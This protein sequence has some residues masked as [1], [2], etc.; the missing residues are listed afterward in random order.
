MFTI[1]TKQKPEPLTLGNAPLQYVDE[2]TYL[3]VNFDKRQTWK[4]QIGIAESKARKKLCSM[5]KLA[6]TNC[7]ANE[8]ILKQVYHGNIRPSLE[9]GSGAFM[10][11]A[12]SH[13]DNLEKVQNQALRVITGAMRSTPIEKMQKITGIPP[14]KRRF[15]SKALTLYT[16]AEALKDHPL[17]DRTKQR[18]RG[19]LGRESFIGQAKALKEKFK[20]DL[21]IDIEAIQIAD[22]WKEAPVQYKIQTAVPHLGPKEVTSKEQ[23]RS[24]TLEMIEDRYPDEAWTHI[25]T[26]GSASDAVKNR[27]AGVYIQNPDGTTKVMSEPT[28]LHCTNYRAEVEALTI[29][30]ENID[31]DDLQESQIVFLTDALSV[32]QDLEKGNLPKLRTALRKLECTRVTL[33]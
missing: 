4:S 3:G 24:L 5:R 14:L 33:Q 28:G 20:E 26:D 2:Q 17:H 9:F 12:N 23:R 29:A 15:E 10:T 30:A 22:D 13:L 11:A 25:Y 16:K 31:K 18:G 1:K 27:G 21:P 6:G 32:L 7:G 8:K 19:R